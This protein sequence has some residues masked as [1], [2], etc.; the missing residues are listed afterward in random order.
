VREWIVNW[1]C[2]DRVTLSTL[3]RDRKPVPYHVKSD[4]DGKTTTKQSVSICVHPW[5]VIQTII[6]VYIS[7]C[8]H[9]TLTLLVIIGNDDYAKNSPLDK[10]EKRRGVR[11]SGRASTGSGTAYQIDKD[12]PILAY[13]GL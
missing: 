10:G 9:A 2:R 6:E 8:I 13:S 3:I 7:L 12:Y 11:K 1:F 5:F 4:F